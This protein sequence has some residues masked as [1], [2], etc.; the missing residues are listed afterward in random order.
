MLVYIFRIHTLLA[1]KQLFCSAVSHI[2]HK[3][4]FVPYL[5][6]T[7]FRPPYGK[8]ILFLFIHPLPRFLRSSLLLK[9]IGVRFH[10][11]KVFQ[12]ILCFFR[13]LNVSWIL[14]QSHFASKQH[15]EISQNLLKDATTSLISS[16][17]PDFSQDV[18]PPHHHVR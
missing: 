11:I 15:L 16:G 13:S 8:K 6:T 7:C 12:I 4:Y 14:L 17:S 18:F 5:R 2:I 9:V 1:T 3:H 10:I